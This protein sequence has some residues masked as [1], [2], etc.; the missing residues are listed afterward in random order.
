MGAALNWA[1]R[2]GLRKG[3][4]EGRG[5][6]LVV[7]VAAGMVRLM[8]RPPKTEV[9]RFTVSPGQRYAIVCSDEPGRR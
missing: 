5:P 8:R 4:G 9:M 3:V 1:F 6:W 7:A 2:T